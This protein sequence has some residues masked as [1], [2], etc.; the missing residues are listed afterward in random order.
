MTLNS[1]PYYAKVIVEQE[2]DAEYNEALES[3]HEI[4]A[5]KILDK[6]IFLVYAA[7]E[8]GEDLELRKVINEISSDLTLLNFYTITINLRLEESSDT[9]RTFLYNYINILSEDSYIFLFGSNTL[10][11]I[12]QEFDSVYLKKELSLLRSFISQDESPCTTF[13]MLTKDNPKNLYPSIFDK[14][15]VDEKTRIQIWH[16]LSYP[17]LI[18]TI[19][20]KVLSQKEYEAAKVT[21]KH[22]LLEVSNKL[23]NSQN[24]SEPFIFESHRPVAEK[25]IT[26][27]V[28]SRK[29]LVQRKTKKLLSLAKIEKKTND[30]KELLEKLE[31]S[32]ADH[33]NRDYDQKRDIVFENIHQPV[34]T[35]KFLLASETNFSRTKLRSDS[36]TSKQHKVFPSLNKQLPASRSGLFRNHR[37]DDRA[38]L[39]LEQILPA[40][41]RLGAALNRE[42]CFFDAAAQSLTSKGNYT[43]KGLRMLCH[44]YVVELD[45]G[46]KEKNW[47]YQRFLKDAQ[48]VN[49]NDVEKAAVNNYQHYLANIQFT[50]DEIDAGDGLNCTTA[51]WGEQDL[52]GR[53]LR[54][55]LGVNLHVLELHIHNGKFIRGHQLN[56]RSVSGDV[57]SYNA[58]D[59]VHIANFNNHFVPILPAANNVSIKK[60][61]V[62]RRSPSDSNSDAERASEPNMEHSSLS[63][64]IVAAEQ[65]LTLAP[66]LAAPEIKIRGYKNNPQEISLKKALVANASYIQT[67]VQAKGEWSCERWLQKKPGISIMEGES[68]T[69]KTLR[70]EAIL[71]YLSQDEAACASYPGGVYFLDFKNLYKQANNTEANS[72]VQSQDDLLADLIGRTFLVRND[73]FQTLTVN[74]SVWLKSQKPSLFIYENITTANLNK[75]ENLLFVEE[76]IKSHKII[77]TTT[78]FN[79]RNKLLKKSA[80][81]DSPFKIKPFLKITSALKNFFEKI[82]SYDESQNL[83]F[84]PLAQLAIRESLANITKKLQYWPVLIKLFY[85]SYRAIVDMNEGEAAKQF[86]NSLLSEIARDLNS[87]KSKFIAT[88]IIRN[89]QEISNSILDKQLLPELLAYIA[90]GDNNALSEGPIFNNTDFAWTFKRFGLIETDDDG[91]VRVHNI[92]QTQMQACLENNANAESLSINSLTV[93]SAFINKVYNKFREF[94]EIESYQEQDGTK[95]DCLNFDFKTPLNDFDEIM[96]HAQALF[97]YLRKQNSLEPLIEDLKQLVFIKANMALIFY[98]KGLY[99]P[100]KEAIDLICNGLPEPTSRSSLLEKIWN[101]FSAPKKEK[102]SGVKIEIF[103]DSERFNLHNLAFLINTQLNKYGAMTHALSNEQSLQKENEINEKRK[104]DNLVA[105]LKRAVIG[106]SSNAEIFLQAGIAYTVF[107]S[108]LMEY[109]EHGSYPKHI[110][111]QK[112]IFTDFIEKNYRVDSKDK[113]FDEI[114]QLFSAAYRLKLHHYSLINK[115]SDDFIHRAQ[116]ELA[117][118]ELR[119][120][121]S[122]A[123]RN[124]YEMALEKYF[125]AI[126]KLKEIYNDSESYH[127]AI[128]Y[129][130]RGDLYR[131]LGLYHQAEKEIDLAIK[132]FQHSFHAFHKELV[133]CKVIQLKINYLSKYIFQARAGIERMLND[134]RNFIQHDP[135]KIE[136]NLYHARTLITQG[137]HEESDIKLQRCWQALK[138][139][140]LETS[141]IDDE[142][143]KFLVY[144]K[145]G[146]YYSR[147]AAQILHYQGLN[148]YK[149]GLYDNARLLYIAALKIELW[150]LDSSNIKLRQTS[151]NI[152]DLGVTQFKE[153]KSVKVAQTLRELA[154]IYYRENK[155]S[156]A[157]LLLKDVKQIQLV[158]YLKAHQLYAK[159]KRLEIPQTID[160]LSIQEV[161]I[162]RHCLARV[163]IAQGKYDEAR[164]EIVSIPD[165]DNDT[166][167]NYDI[168]SIHYTQAKLDYVVGNLA[169]AYT[170]IKEAKS[171]FKR[172]NKDV[173]KPTENI[174]YIR[175]LRL[176]ALILLNLKDYDAAESCLLESLT[177]IINLFPHRHPETLMIY[178][179]LGD[180][181]VAMGKYKE[182]YTA[183]CNA[184]D[185]IQ[186]SVSQEIYY[187]HP[188]RMQLL[189]RYGWY[190]VQLGLSNLTQEIT[191]SHYGVECLL[192]ARTI[193][194]NCYEAK[195]CRNNENMSTYDYLSLELLLAYVNALLHGYLNEPSLAEKALQHLQTFKAELKAKLKSDEQ[196]IW[197]P[198]WIYII[199]QGF[200]KEAEAVSQRLE[201]ENAKFPAKF[202]K[203]YLALLE[204]IINNAESALDPVNQKILNTYVQRIRISRC[205]NNENI[206]QSTNQG[207]TQTVFAGVLDQLLKINDEKGAQAFTEFPELVNKL[208]INPR[209]IQVINE[210]SLINLNDDRARMLQ[211]I[212]LGL[213]YAFLGYY[214]TTAYYAAEIKHLLAKSSQLFRASKK[215]IEYVQT[216]LD[217]FSRYYTKNSIRNSKEKREPIPLLESLLKQIDEKFIFFRFLI[218]LTLAEIKTATLD[219]SVL[220][221]DSSELLELNKNLTNALAMQRDNKGLQNWGWY[222]AAEM[223]MYKIK[224]KPRFNDAGVTSNFLLGKSFLVKLFNAVNSSNLQLT[225]NLAKLMDDTLYQLQQVY[226]ENSSHKDMLLAYVL[227]G[228]YLI[229]VGDYQK[230]EEAFLKAIDGY[231]KHY[232]LREDQQDSLV[233]LREAERWLLVTYF[234]SANFIKLQRYTSEL[235]IRIE[236]H[237]KG[238]F[239]HVTQ[240]D[241]ATYAD[242]VSSDTEINTYKSFYYYLVKVFKLAADIT[243]LSSDKLPTLK[244]DILDIQDYLKSHTKPNVKLK[245]TPAVDLDYLKCLLI[246]AM[247]LYV[248]KTGISLSK[249]NFVMADDCMNAM[250]KI[251]QGNTRFNV[252]QAFYN[253]LKATCLIKKDAQSYT[254]TAKPRKSAESRVFKYLKSAAS[255]Y[256]RAYGN[257]YN[258]HPKICELAYLLNLFIINAS[259]HQLEIPQELPTLE[260]IKCY[261]DRFKIF[262]IQHGVDV[263]QL[264][265]LFNFPATINWKEIIDW[266]S[267]IK[268]FNDIELTKLADNVTALT[269]REAT[270][271]PLTQLNSNSLKDSTYVI[272]KTTE[273]YI[274]TQFHSDLS[275]ALHAASTEK[276]VKLF[277]VSG[278]SGYGKTQLAYHTV[279]KLADDKALLCRIVYESFDE[280]ENN[281]IVSIAMKG[282][283]AYIDLLSKFGFKGKNAIAEFQ[284]YLSKHET[285]TTLILDNFPNTT[286]LEEVEL[287]IYPYLA[288]KNKQNINLNIII[289]TQENLL[290]RKL[291]QLGLVTSV[292]KPINMKGGF[293]L[294]EASCLLSKKLGVDAIGVEAMQSLGKSSCAPI[295]LNQVV[296]CIKTTKNRDVD[297]ERFIKEADW[298]LFFDGNDKVNGLVKKYWQHLTHNEKQIHRLIALISYYTIPIRIVEHYFINNNCEFLLE[299][300]TH[301]C[302]LLEYETDIQESNAT[303]RIHESINNIFYKILE[304][305]VMR[306]VVLKTNKTGLVWRKNG[307][308]EKEKSKEEI[309]YNEIEDYLKAINDAFRKKESIVP[310]N[311]RMAQF[312]AHFENLHKKLQSL[313]IDKLVKKEIG[314]LHGNLGLIY[315]DKFDATNDFK[316]KNDAETHLKLAYDICLVCF[317]EEGVTVNVQYANYINIAKPNQHLDNLRAIR[318][319]IIGDK[320]NAEIARMDVDLINIVIINNYNILRVLKDDIKNFN[321]E[322]DIAKNI[323]SCVSDLTKKQEYLA[324]I[325]TCQADCFWRHKKGDIDSLYK[326]YKSAKQAV[327]A[328]KKSGL[329]VEIKDTREDSAIYLRAVI[330]ESLCLLGLIDGSSKTDVLRKDIN[331]LL[332]SCI[333]KKNHICGRYEKFYN[334]MAKDNQGAIEELESYKEFY[335]QLT[336]SDK[337]TEKKLVNLKTTSSL[338]GQ[339]LADSALMTRLASEDNKDLAEVEITTP[340]PAV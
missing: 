316:Y 309:I 12:T 324:W 100:A 287:L 19:L 223:K 186:M 108:T 117:I 211:Q 25:I 325:Y 161:H 142:I 148:L 205:N 44:G 302:A 190:Y 196:N 22:Q 14:V 218:E 102:N 39:K 242:I 59:T 50:A 243:Q 254:K 107:S 167:A 299:E 284:Q 31:D 120:G 264:E 281:S 63:P 330:I 75:L 295:F 290:V 66:G 153:H 133:R 248:S 112:S 308:K 15:L 234:L 219:K 317:D 74:L 154:N 230:A 131:C 146:I 339:I 294:E 90:Y 300:G 51:I 124:N 323:I 224:I 214:H 203:Q 328:F 189:L 217:A 147:F 30:S 68:G 297:C 18:N 334:E 207:L 106:K 329:L 260:N 213:S 210:L 212:L 195:R 181:Y 221:K 57:I 310:P 335:K 163:F 156:K 46:S 239:G 76:N 249:A 268:I 162:T 198:S 134:D 271:P 98:L 270:S 127:L 36:D 78:D 143:S 286:T 233:N 256:K 337:I 272:R 93:F 105:L 33:G 166:T 232:K 201:I 145:D 73:N 159:E 263:A 140:K 298:P 236:V 303:L 206:F 35:S 178:W 72:L 279:A 5:D 251:C 149:K 292:I 158:T 69:G 101:I 175:L 174:Q 258:P 184:D 89:L 62:Q 333:A 121:M 55:Q 283:Q 8:E 185:L 20:D 216:Y 193:Y 24:T 237:T 40:N 3:I 235:L 322:F 13:V 179:G 275:N 314:R 96:L 129:R 85:Y 291:Y 2:L 172:L 192:R 253:V 332:K 176:E 77:I 288:Y 32:A 215:L 171:Q 229:Y 182:A 123:V 278:P 109:K 103:K 48:R 311:I 52:D 208:Q 151:E 58:Q 280:R 240:A 168:S 64:Q 188:K 70:L 43:A 200:D 247:Q 187:H 289:T 115:K 267:I 199:T 139:L 244:D 331:D 327:S 157:E 266:Q 29:E 126:G 17:E 65:E 269:E 84:K 209:P 135:D 231:Q 110:E 170:K 313:G 222:V 305:D 194:Q 11:C 80:N 45:K 56:G 191:I 41:V 320:S 86:F 54:E 87:D 21:I 197:H 141:F 128:A 315:A 136:L 10:K 28:E 113:G 169:T 61:E 259:N 293:A 26:M 7:T 116:A 152:I 104:N 265:A 252:Y 4:L 321:E 301:N 9:T 160:E 274:E 318:Q 177:N 306:Q 83:C 1:T 246:V 277:I 312:L 227:Q 49:P 257:I 99:K 92:I 241:K 114:D 60:L 164:D 132:I 228:R 245:N 53:I 226:G 6:S 340:K 261:Q 238:V 319:R 137:K 42:D 150:L 220:E 183:Y 296:S 38:K 37:Q 285:P 16:N 138:E 255:F 95:I 250:E 155:F 27:K 173:A 282:N 125:A 326:T 88:L 23:V 67:L 273:V 304:E 307:D 180:V 111:D 165:T 71:N 144:V 130:C 79:L 336:E 122:F 202:K 262:I 94:L 338:F 47:I 204:L 91:N 97:N 118:T 34:S 119:W 225:F 81:I 82:D 276:G